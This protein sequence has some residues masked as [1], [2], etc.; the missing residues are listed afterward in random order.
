VFARVLEQLLRGG[1]QLV[2]RR[3]SQNISSGLAQNGV[4]LLVHAEEREGGEGG[5]GR[6]QG[7]NMKRVR[8]W[9]PLIVSRDHE[10]IW[11]AKNACRRSRRM[12]S[13]EAMCASKGKY[14]WRRCEMRGV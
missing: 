6:M 12:I 13:G 14:F 8:R 7:A 11:N 3:S 5:G 4:L 2:P 9:A 1:L 10:N